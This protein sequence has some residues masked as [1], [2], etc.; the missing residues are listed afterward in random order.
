MQE[1]FVLRKQLYER[2]KEYMLAKL[3]K[4]FQTL[5]NK[6]RFIQ[7][8][9]SEEIKINR[10]KKRAVVKRLR[11][12]GL[13]THSELNQI[14]PEKKRPSV[15][16]PNEGDQENPD[17]IPVHNEEEEKLGEGEVPAKEY[18]YL[19]TMQ[20][21]SLTEERVLELEKLMKE[22]KAEHD[23]LEKM[24]IYEL[25]QGDLDK[26]LVELEKYEAQEEK[27][28]LAHTAK[29]NG[30]KYKGA[31]KGPAKKAAAGG[32]PAKKND[33]K[34]ANENSDNK[35]GAPGGGGGKKQTNMNG[36]VKKARKNS[37]DSDEEDDYKPDDDSQLPLMERIK[38]KQ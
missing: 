28:R 9:I 14:L 11:E 33:K 17:G 31:K 38:R 3:Q 34:A 20:I 18:D 35:K 32:P 25:W 10:V 5:F 27:D 21:M 37:D 24:H 1:F 13:K 26:F 2:R 29:E 8:V 7:G 36:L 23:R 22:K 6:V 4:E 12:L 30:G 15:Q 19:L 16:Q